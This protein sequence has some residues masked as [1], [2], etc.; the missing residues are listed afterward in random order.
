VLEA[1]RRSEHGNITLK[2]H[3]NP[4]RESVVRAFNIDILKLSD[5]SGASPANRILPAYIVLAAG[6]LTAAAFVITLSPSSTD[7]PKTVAAASHKQHKTKRPAPTAKPRL[8]ATPPKSQSKPAAPPIAGAVPA[9]PAKAPQA[10]I[11]TLNV[12]PGDSLATLFSQHHLSARDLHDIM[13]LGKPTARLQHL[14]PNDV[15][16][17]TQRADGAVAM[18][19]Y[20]YDDEH[21]LAVRRT[22]DGG[23]TSRIAARP[24]K[25][26]VRHAHGVITSSL[27]EAATGAGLSDNLTI[28]LIHIFGW[29]IDFVHDIRAGDQ[30]TVLYQR[31]YHKK[32]RDG[33][34][35]PILAAS[36]TTQ[37]KRYEAIR[38]TDTGGHT[39]YYT[40]DGKSLRKAFLRAPVEYTRI[41]SRFSLHRM[42]PILGYSRAHKGVDYAAPSGTPIKAAGDGRIALRGRNGGYGNC[43][44]I[45]H[46]AK[47]T[48][49]YGHMSRF[50]SGLHV[51]SYVR[52]GQIIGYVGMTGLATGPHLHFELRVHGVA[53]NPRTVKLP[54]AAPIAANYKADFERAATPLIAKLKTLRRAQVAQAHGELQPPSSIAHTAANALSSHSTRQ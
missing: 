2:K 3:Q 12:T 40:P 17:V 31:L 35:G 16:T 51:G 5:Q 20:A 11:I 32:T 36:F 39:D 34:D 19:K 7:A 38:Y 13:A 22:D 24:V 42:H 33:A 52:Q 6:V 28:Q 54:D 8:A 44:I 23:F 9:P 47:Y 45:Q 26:T 18:L 53:K 27:F 29:D 49:V 25:R 50:K 37:D 4:I 21:L 30:F 43:I 46:G 10:P 48:T 15:I 41:S 14:Q 1:H